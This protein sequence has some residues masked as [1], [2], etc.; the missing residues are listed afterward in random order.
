MNDDEYADR[1]R[2]MTEHENV[3][4]DQRL[5]W[6]IASQGLLM[7]AL[8]FSWAK[9]ESLVFSLVVVG[10]LLSVS[11][12]ANLRCNTLAIR[13]LRNS[14]KERCQTGYDGPPVVALKSEEITPNLLRWLYPW[15]VLPIAFTAFWIFVLFYTT[16]G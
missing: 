11:I 2:S 4:R 10:L 13:K 15:N 5:N 7:A 1:I 8:G 16:W 6:L 12:G 14:I 3:L 9:D